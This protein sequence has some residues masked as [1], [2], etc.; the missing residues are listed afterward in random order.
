MTILQLRLCGYISEEG[1]L[2][3]MSSLCKWIILKQRGRAIQQLSRSVGRPAALVISCPS[4]EITSWTRL[5]QN[6]ILPRSAD[7]CCIQRPGTRFLERI[8]CVDH[9]VHDVHRLLHC[10]CARRWTT[11]PPSSAATGRHQRFYKGL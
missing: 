4:Q 5:N 10:M 3:A 7:G 9:G 11:E 2:C 6:S 8:K 1:P